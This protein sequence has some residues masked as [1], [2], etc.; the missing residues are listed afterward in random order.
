MTG[1]SR[2]ILLFVEPSYASSYGGSKRVLVNVLRH[3]DTSRWDVR[4]LFYVPGPYLED[5]SR[6]GIEASA[7]PEL[8]ELAAAHVRA[9]GS[10]KA[11]RF[12]VREGSGGSR[13]RHPIRQWMRNLRAQRRFRQRDRKTAEVLLPHV[14]DGTALIQINNPLLDDQSW[15]HV[16]RKRDLPYLTWEH[17]IWREP[18]GP[19]R[20]VVRRAAAV[21]CL[22]PERADL[23]RHHCGEQV[24]A[25]VVP[26]GMDL[27]NFR[28]AR[29]AEEIRD[30]LGLSPDTLMLATAGH[31]KRWKGQHLALEAASLLHREGVDFHWFF[32]GQAVERS[33]YDELQEQ[34][35]ALGL[36]QNVS[37]LDQRSDVPDLFA[38]SDLAVHTSVQ[39]E[40]F[41]MVV[42][43][44]MSVGTPVIGPREGAIP[45]IV[46]DGVDGLLYEPRSASSLA[47]AIGRA[48]ADAAVRTEMG[49]R[50]RHRVREEFD[51]QRQ[52]ARLSTIYARVLG[53]PSF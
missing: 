17:G 15:Y 14:P 30:Q 44:A 35:R 49:L 4:A 11:P 8:G 47:G 53:Q 10:T 5:L 23:L 7:P 37:L 33:Y 32:F 29:D 3:L 24:T 34:V 38:A 1:Q 42:V 16:A 25:E 20:S 12:G 2:P 18:T 21:I 48:A 13:Q 19:Y 28:V 40:P 46:R 45:T 22:T 51:V 31:Y 9:A 52:V 50:A 43:E 6:L 27:D 36:E 26:N 39:P 41:G